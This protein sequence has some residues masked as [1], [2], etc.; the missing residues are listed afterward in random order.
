MRFVIEQKMFMENSSAI[1][2]QVSYVTPQN[3]VLITL[4][5]PDGTTIQQAIEMSGIKREIE[6]KDWDQLKV[7]IYS[8]IKKLDTI[9]KEH[10]RIEIYRALLVDPMVARRARALKK[11]S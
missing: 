4:M 1:L 7:G 5:V 10:D 9:L 8:K 2:I 3:Q 11:T 6:S